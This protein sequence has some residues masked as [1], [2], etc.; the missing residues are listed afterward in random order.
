MDIK[1]FLPE[2]IPVLLDFERERLSSQLSEIEREM[3]SWD[4]SW[5]EE[6]LQHY[7]QLGWSFI[8]EQEGRLQ[9]YI[10]AQPL[11]FFNKWTQS[12]WVEHMN[13]VEDPHG[14]MLIDTVVRWAKTK[15]LQKVIV[16][17]ASDKV[18]FVEQNLDSMKAGAFLH[19]S[20]TKI[21]EE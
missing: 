5:R 6:S 20:T 17:S 2:H 19:L 8:L 14:E 7:S 11:L 18:G 3:A 13:F 9:G 15:H 12:L 21:Q 10:L 1:L 16:N 4:T